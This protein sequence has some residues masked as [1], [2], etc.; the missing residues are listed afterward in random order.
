MAPRLLTT[1]YF[2]LPTVPLTHIPLRT[3]YPR[4]TLPFIHSKQLQLMLYLCAA[5][6]AP[7][8]LINFPEPLALYDY[9]ADS[10][11][12]GY[13]LACSATC[14]RE[15]AQ[16]EEPGHGTPRLEL[17]ELNKRILA[18]MSPEEKAAALEVMSPKERAAAC[19][20]AE[21]NQGCAAEGDESHHIT[22]PDVGALHELIE[23]CWDAAPKER[24]SFQE[25]CLRMEGAGF[26]S[27]DRVHVMDVQHNQRTRTLR[28]SRSS[29]NGSSHSASYCPDNELDLSHQFCV[30]RETGNFQK[31]WCLQQQ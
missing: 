16:L 3:T 27:S 21:S 12:F 10:F 26:N 6:T 7:E 22:P 4:P 11:S 20:I 5:Y 28:M 15:V 13:V 2:A 17:E 23:R 1:V 29:S 25:I 30:D 24:A 9:S 14:N 8:V 19:A 18:A 31:Q